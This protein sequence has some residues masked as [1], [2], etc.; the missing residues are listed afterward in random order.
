[1]QVILDKV[2]TRIFGKEVSVEFSSPIRGGCI[3]ETLVLSLSNKEKVF[4][5]Y[6]SNPPNDYFDTEVHG[7]NILRSAAEG[8]EVPEVLFCDHP[9][10]LVLEYIKEESAGNDFY[11]SFG[12]AMAALHQTSQTHY[13]FN[14]DNFIG[15][16]AQCNTQEEDPIVFFREHRLRFQ[17]HLAKKRGL[18]SARANR[19]LDSLCENLGDFLDVTGEKPALSHGDLWSGNYLCGLGQKPFIFD[20]AA[21]FGLREADLAMTELF[22]KLP[23]QFYSAYQEVFPLNPGYKERK[24]LFNLYH[25]LN[26][27]NLFGGPYL[28]SMEST[29]NK[30]IR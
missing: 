19:K 7:L 1:M 2:L 18:L 8:P 30:F 9:N 4:L 10:V 12:R 14:H 28:S 20:P 5:K 16:T 22:G 6:N 26:H 27:V 21:H 17:Q 25:L 13:G 29:L 11:E 3:N 15:K 24:H 23:K